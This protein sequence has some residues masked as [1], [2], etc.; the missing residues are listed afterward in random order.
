MTFGGNV[1]GLAQDITGL[2]GSVLVEDLQITSLLAEWPEA[3]LPAV[4][5]YMV[6]SF[7]SGAFETLA[8]TFEGQFNKIAQTLT[9]SKLSLNGEIDDVEVTTGYG[10]YEA[11]TGLAKGRLSVDVGAGGQLTSAKM[12][13]SLSDGAI[14]VLGREDAIV[15][16]QAAGE[17]IYEPGRVSVPDARFIFS[18][19]SELAASCL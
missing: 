7:S 3:A 6:E 15:F 4:R 11:L 9:L 19:A 14:K 12:K 18:E 17:V 2:S 16:E 13:L 1:A 8:V 5:A 10:Q